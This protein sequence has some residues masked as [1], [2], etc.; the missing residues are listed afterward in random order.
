M[1]RI[2]PDRWPKYFPTAGANSPPLVLPSANGRQPR[3]ELLGVDHAPDLPAI[4]WKL[5]NLTRMS[6]T[7]RDAAIAELDRVLNTI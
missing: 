1:I 2:G 3:W 7:Q 5:H 6:A 4:R